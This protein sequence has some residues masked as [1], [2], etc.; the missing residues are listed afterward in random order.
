MDRAYK[1]FDRDGKGEFTYEELADHLLRAG[2]VFA[3]ETLISLAEDIDTDNDGRIS[4][5]IR[6]QASFNFS[7]ALSSSYSIISR[8]SVYPGISSMSLRGSL[9]A[10]AE[11]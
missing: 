2:A 6:G 7:G 1:E 3:K 11:S 10:I 9:K 5:V 4:K 8:V